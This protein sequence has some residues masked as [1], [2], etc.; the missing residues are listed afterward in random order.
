MTEKVFAILETEHWTQKNSCCCNEGQ[1]CPTQIKR[2]HHYM[3]MEVP[4][5]LPSKASQKHFTLFAFISAET[6]ARLC[7]PFA[8]PFTGGYKGL[9]QNCTGSCVCKNITVK[10][11][12][13]QQPHYCLHQVQGR[14]GTLKKTKISFLFTLKSSVFRKHLN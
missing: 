1:R 3:T 10:V 9:Q 11:T 2:I 13:P 12:S 7:Q 4:R 6:E 5:H 14:F 8:I